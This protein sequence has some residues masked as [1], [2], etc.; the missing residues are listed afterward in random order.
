M[1][2]KTIRRTIL[3]I[4]VSYM[5]RL[6]VAAETRSCLRHLRM[7]VVLLN[8][9][10]ISFQTLFFIAQTCYMSRI[11]Q[12]ETCSTFW[13]VK[14][15]SDILVV[16]DGIFICFNPLPANVENMVSY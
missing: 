1:H 7:Y 15:L 13:A 11:S 4:N 12:T 14:L 10:M 5:F 8:N 6:P 9:L 2:G 3:D 16:N